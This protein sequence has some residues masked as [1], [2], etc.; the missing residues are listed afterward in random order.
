M[1]NAALGLKVAG[2]FGKE[3]CSFT[4]LRPNTP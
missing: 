4:K 3:L 1:G 2:Y